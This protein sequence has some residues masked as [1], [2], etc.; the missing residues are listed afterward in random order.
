MTFNKGMV[1]TPGDPLLPKHLRGWSDPRTLYAIKKEKSTTVIARAFHRALRSFA[2]MFL[3][4]VLTLAALAVG[5]LIGL[6]SV[7]CNDAPRPIQSIPNP[8]F[9]SA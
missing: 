6:K 5:M 2:H 1:E 3:A 8:E 9:V 4:V 7:R